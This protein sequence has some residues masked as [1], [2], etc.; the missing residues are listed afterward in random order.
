ML[1]RYGVKHPMRS[2]V[3]LEKR[4]S[5]SFKKYGV[6]SP[7]GLKSVLNK[8]IVTWLKN[9]GVDNPFKSANVKSK[10][11]YVESNR[12]R[13]ETLIAEGR[14]FVSKPE[15]D[16]GKFLS[17]TF[18][19]DDIKTQSWIARHS[20]DFYVKSLDLYIQVDGVYWHGLMGEERIND[21]IRVTMKNDVATMKWFEQHEGF[22]LFRLTDLQWGKVVKQHTY[23][24]LVEQLRSASNAVSYFVHEPGYPLKEQNKTTENVVYGDI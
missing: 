11:D 8:R 22:K 5:N 16:V 9:Y 24:V 7:S 13:R 23:D 6:S 10:I 18:G 15:R 3:V 12:K 1:E 4:R 17:S 20:I 14:L 19:V 2:S 21:K